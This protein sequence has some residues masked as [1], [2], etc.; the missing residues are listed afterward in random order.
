MAADDNSL[1]EGTDHII[2]GAMKI[3]QGGG[4][5]T[6]GFVA[7]GNVDD[8]TGGTAMTDDQGNGLGSQIRQGVASLKQ[9]AGGR[10]RDAA[11]DGKTRAS[12]ALEHISRIVEEAAESIEDRL[13][14][15]FS[16]I[17]RKA[18]EAV[19]GFATTL[20]E[21]D[22]DQLYEDINGFVRKSPALAIG[23]A[24]A[25]GFVAVRL[26]KAGLPDADAEENDSNAPAAGRA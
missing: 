21:R 25:V 16:P 18:A 17:A 14:P 24:A 7:S 15:E 4:D 26:I 11:D 1:P 2:N 19:G 6:S 13:G 23:I 9:Q 22:P 12:D 8:D 20:R 5:P 3:E 10:I